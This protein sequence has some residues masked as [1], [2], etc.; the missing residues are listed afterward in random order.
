MKWDETE[1]H[2]KQEGVYFFGGQDAR[3]QAVNTLVILTFSINVNHVVSRSYLKPETVG[4]PPLPRYQHSMD[5]F[6]KGNVIVIAGGRNDQMQPEKVL[7]DIW[8][9]KL[10]NLE[11]LRVKLGGAEYVKPRFNFAS[12]I[13]GTKLII[14]GGLGHEFRFL[15]DY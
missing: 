4:L 5:Y 11:W 6:A 12:C 3:S 7:N 9:L 14:A 13:I 8:V 2:I 10:N 1:H 15:Q